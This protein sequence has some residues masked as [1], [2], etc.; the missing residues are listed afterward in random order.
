MDSVTGIY[1]KYERYGGSNSM[2]NSDKDSDSRDERRTKDDNHDTIEE[3]NSEKLCTADNDNEKELESVTIKYEKY[4]DAI[5]RKKV[6]EAYEK[7]LLDEALVK[8]KADEE[9]ARKEA[10]KALERK[11]VE[12]ALKRKIA[13]DELEIKK[14]EKTLAEEELA[15]IK[16]EATNNEKETL[17]GNCSDE[18]GD[19]YLDIEQFEILETIGK[20]EAN[21]FIVTSPDFKIY[22]SRWFC[23]R[24]LVSAQALLSVFCPENVVI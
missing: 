17:E 16:S 11:N 7:K 12:E 1:G 18:D 20:G 8:K 9:L 15:R 24:M 14:A 4:G 6:K 21:L 10:E 3:D 2:V 13:E 22:I 5:E 19:G 23:P